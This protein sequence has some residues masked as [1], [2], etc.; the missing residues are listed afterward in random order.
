MLWLFG[1]CEFDGTSGTIGELKGKSEEFVTVRRKIRDI[2]DNSINLRGKAETFV[3]FNREIEEHRVQCN[4]FKG[5]SG[6][7]C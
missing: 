3:N 2:G 7:S 5:K 4:H 6:N 1:P